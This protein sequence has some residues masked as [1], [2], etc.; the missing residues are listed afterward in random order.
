MPGTSGDL[1]GA[2]DSYSRSLFQMWFLPWNVCQAIKG[3]STLQSTQF[4]ADV[5]PGVGDRHRLT[6]SKSL[7]PGIPY[8]G[9]NETVPDSAVQFA[10][11]VLRPGDPTFR[12]LIEGHAVHSLPGATY[13]GEVTVV[14]D[15]RGQPVGTPVTVW[16]VVS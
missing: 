14:D 6:L 4:S 11:A 9:L 2:V 1:E 13:W 12:L 15:T 3:A 8:A 16:L 10:P 7:A 5:V